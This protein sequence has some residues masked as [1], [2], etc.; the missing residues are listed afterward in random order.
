MAENCPRCSGIGVI[1][2]VFA[3]GPHSCVCGLCD[4]L[5]QIPNALV[6]SYEYLQSVRQLR[7][8]AEKS[9]RTTAADADVSSV[10]IL[11]IESGVIDLS[12]H[13]HRKF[14]HWL[15]CNEFQPSNSIKTTQ[16][17]GWFEMH[18]NPFYVDGDGS[19]EPIGVVDDDYIVTAVTRASS[20]VRVTGGNE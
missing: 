4:G 15:L 9:I 7:V 16:P 20:K 5:K 2:H 3:T 6:S 14:L 1:T 18:G 10:A 11:S 19:T 17:G 12:S 8:D 13:E